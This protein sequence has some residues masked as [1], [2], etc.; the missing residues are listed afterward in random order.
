M[1]P[2]RELRL[3]VGDLLQ[4]PGT[5][6]EVDRELPVP[7]LAVTGS[8]VPAGTVAMVSLVVASTADPGTLTVAGTVSAAWRGTCRRCLEPIEGELETEVH[9]VVARVPVDEEVWALHGDEV[10]LG[11]IVREALL[12]AL[13]LAPLCSEDCRGPVPEEFPAVPEH[14]AAQQGEDEDDVPPRDP[15]WAALEQLRFD[16]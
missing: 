2:G 5:R 7:H 1:T 4:R 8:E 11:S 15:R 14:D 9:E 13:P 3:G 10:D 16:D 6:R 12:L